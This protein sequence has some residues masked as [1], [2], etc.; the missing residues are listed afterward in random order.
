MP[1][2][3]GRD[4]WTD[5][6]DGR[7]MGRNSSRM[8]TRTHPKRCFV[9]FL[10]MIGGLDFPK[11]VGEHSLAGQIPKPRKNIG[12]YLT[13]E[14]FLWKRKVNLNSPKLFFQ[15]SIFPWV[16][17]QQ[18]ENIGNMLDCEFLELNTPI[19]LHAPPHHQ[20]PFLDRSESGLDDHEVLTMTRMHRAKHRAT[21]VDASVEATSDQG[22]Q[23]P[24]SKGSLTS[25]NSRDS[26][27][28]G[29]RNFQSR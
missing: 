11:S 4:S 17:E 2:G 20:P 29:W 9:L 8:S 26:W 23:N 22:T 16:G 1:S 6:V 10:S 15:W 25:L 14:P 19:H 24:S 5:E 21:C 27:G 13:F 18:L 28:S 7:A 12:G 3:R